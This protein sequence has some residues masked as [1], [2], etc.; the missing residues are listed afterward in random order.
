MCS[1]SSNVCLLFGHCRINFIGLTEGSQSFYKC[2]GLVA[3]FLDEL[4]SFDHKSHQYTVNEFG[5]DIL[6]EIAVNCVKTMDAEG[7]ASW[8]FLQNGN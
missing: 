1:I 3:A 7:Q 4:T 6:Q 5:F 2:S 8:N